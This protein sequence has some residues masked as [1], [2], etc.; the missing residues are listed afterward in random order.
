MEPNEIAALAQRIHNAERWDLG[1]RSTRETRNAFWARVVGI[2]HHGHPV[3]N[4]TPDPRWHLKSGGGGR[5]QSDDVAVRMP[6]RHF[7][8]FIGGV[9][10]DG[11][12]FGASADHGPLP[13]EQPVF[14]PPVPDGGGVAAPAVGNIWT[15]KHQAIR[16]RL[17]AAD[18]RKIAEQLAY[19]F[20][21]EGWG[22][23]RADGSRPVS[24]DV[25]ARTVDG[26]LYGMRVVPQA[27]GSPFVIQG[28]IFVPV[29]PVN[30][31]P[32]TVAPPVEPVPAVT[33]EGEAPTDREHAAPAVD[34]SPRFDI[35]DA[36]VGE[37]MALVVRLSAQVSTFYA[38]AEDLKSQEFAINWRTGTIAP[39]AK[40]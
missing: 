6:D 32:V 28:Q 37:L 10:A 30:H 12:T 17:G 33:G 5:P 20:P 35:L 25:I 14:P 9:G 38:L 40:P 4:P 29:S 1:A 34:Y 36:N 8:D 22:Q 27:S 39:K 3:Y 23:K 26:V 15:A 13:M 18:T 11:Y 19:N 16:E 2:V 7:W 21:G 24:N 31:L